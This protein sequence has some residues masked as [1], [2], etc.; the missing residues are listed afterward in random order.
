MRYLARREYTQL[1]LEQKLRPH[2]QSSQELDQLI[3]TLLQ[4]DLLNN[5]RAAESYLRVKAP[6][7]GRLRLQHLLR[8]RG[9]DQEHI[10]WAFSQLEQSEQERA[11]GVWSKRFGQAP[12]TAAEEAKQI[13]FLSARGFSYDTI[14][15]II[16]STKQN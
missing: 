4:K 16:K 2:A 10:E 11:W 9:L 13:R 3:H 12:L 5:Q 14:I 1:E 7:M 6:Q 15:Q 8:E